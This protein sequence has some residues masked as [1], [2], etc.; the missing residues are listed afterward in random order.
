MITLF[1]VS[2][3]IALGDASTRSRHCSSSNA[4]R[5]AK[6]GPT[7]PLTE[8][9]FLRILGRSGSSPSLGSTLVARQVLASLLAA[10]GHHF[11]PDDISL[12]DA[13]LFER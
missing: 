12:M 13:H 6:A 11:W 8:N 9:A 2:V 4:A 1:D 3:L 5:C 7:C 10:P